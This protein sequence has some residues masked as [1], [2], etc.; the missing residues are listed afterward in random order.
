MAAKKIEVSR[1]QTVKFKD[2]DEPLAV[3][4]VSKFHNSIYFKLTMKNFFSFV[5]ICISSFAF[6]QQ[7]SNNPQI[8]P[9][10]VSRIE[11]VL[12]SDAMEGRRVFSSWHR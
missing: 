5:C 4:A 7:A 9:A 2:N 12:S 1:R 8:D 11:K 3:H 10:E 6:A